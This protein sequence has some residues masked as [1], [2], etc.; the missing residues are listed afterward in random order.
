[1]DPCGC[2]RERALPKNHASNKGAGWK[3]MYTRFFRF[4]VAAVVIFL[5]MQYGFSIFA[6]RRQLVWLRLRNMYDAVTAY[7]K[8]QPNV[9]GV[10][11]NST[12]Y[13]YSP[14]QKN[15]LR[16]SGVE[17]TGG[18]LVL[19]TSRVAAVGPHSTTAASTQR[20]TQTRVMTTQMTTVTDMTTQTQV[21]SFTSTNRTLVRCPPLPPNIGKYTCILMHFA[22][23]NSISLQSTPNICHHSFM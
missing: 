21:T 8:I 15:T 22:D 19:T 1:M 18:H 4:S 13:T 9:T 6:T 10:A 12:L 7:D 20:T 17:A 5:G 3:C 23:K 11:W 14:L 2:V 16:R